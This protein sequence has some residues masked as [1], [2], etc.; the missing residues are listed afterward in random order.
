MAKLKDLTNKTYG[1][2]IVNKFAGMNASG[3]STWYCEC[4]CGHEKNNQW[5]TFTKRCCEI[6]WLLW[7]F[8]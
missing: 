2:L 1:K 8:L 5:A 6:V 4:E 7:L 3:G